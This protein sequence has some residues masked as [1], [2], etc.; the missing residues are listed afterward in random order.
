MDPMSQDEESRLMAEKERAR[1]AQEILEHPLFREALDTYRQRLMAE[2]A[3]SPAR[4]TQGREALWLMVKTA[5]AVERH[6]SSLME[7][8][9]LASLQLEQNRSLRER[10]KDWV[11]VN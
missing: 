7:T 6:L 1:Q 8:G 5:E 9:Q 11:G 3:A 2:W 4:D 10:L